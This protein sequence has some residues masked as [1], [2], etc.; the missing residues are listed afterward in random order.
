MGKVS[1]KVRGHVVQY[2]PQQEER[3]EVDIFQPMTIFDLLKQLQVDPQLIM[4][5]HINGQKQPKAALVNVGDEVL[6]FSPPA[7][8]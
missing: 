1:I 5:V 6:L 3:F 4:M 2:F 8:G 7:G